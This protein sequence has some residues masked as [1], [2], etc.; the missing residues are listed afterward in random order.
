[1]QYSSSILTSKKVVTVV[2]LSLFLLG[3]AAQASGSYGGGFGNN[4]GK[5]QYHK[6]KT[7]MQKKL[8]CS[9]CALEGTKIDKTTAP[10]VLQTIQTDSG[11]TAEDKQ[12]AA[13]YLTRR[14]KIKK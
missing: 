13:A 11:L 4:G 6:G 8:L 2:G 1:M 3:N 9:G 10:S 5:A 7:V 12:A 14:Y